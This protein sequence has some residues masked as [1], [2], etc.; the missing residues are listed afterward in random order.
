MMLLNH[1]KGVVDALAFSP[2]SRWLAAV[3]EHGHVV[4]SWDLSTQQVARFW[5]H[6]YRV[7]ALAFAP[8]RPGLLVSCDTVG[9]VR[10]RDITSESSTGTN[11]AQLAIE[12]GQTVR[13]AFSPSGETLAATA[14]L[15]E[16]RYRDHRVRQRVSLWEMN[17]SK[18]TQKCALQVG[19]KVSCVTFHPDGTT[20]AVGT[21]ERA[22]RIYHS[23]SGMMLYELDHGTKVHHLAYSPEGRY[24]VAASPRGLIRV[25]E[26]A[27]GRCRVTLKGQSSCLHAVAFSLDGQLLA[28]AGEDGRVRFWEVSTGRSRE[29]LDWQIGAL[30]AV[31]FAPDGM[32]AAAGGLEGAVMLWDID[33]WAL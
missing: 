32:R 27:T 25:W 18:A 14:A 29:A 13:L 11:L 20:L 21:F 22:V 26:T 5:P 6:R 12:P 30:H 15:P 3:G 24:L 16:S 1:H 9:M 31:A 23:R 10:I 2:E 19:H 4:W 8:D 33:H 17:G 28:T 7:V